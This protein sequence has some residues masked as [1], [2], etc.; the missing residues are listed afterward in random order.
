MGI[1]TRLKNV[2]EAD[3]YELIDQKEQ[4]NPIAMLSHY[5]RQCEKEVE[6]AKKLVERH[7]TLE[8]QYEKEWREAVKMAEKRKHQATVAKEAGADELFEHAIKEEKQY[9]ERASRLF[10]L[11]EQTEKELE[12]LE[13]KY[14]QM[15]HKLKDM[16]VKKLELMGRENSA[17]AHYRMNQVLEE[18]SYK[19]KTF[20]RFEEMERYLDEL[21]QK[22][23]ARYME[24]T[25]DSKITQ[26]EKELKAKKTTPSND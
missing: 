9:E 25:F 3:L 5:L 10:T 20:T 15:K 22:V 1:F 11:K 23:Q 12:Q 18:D 24:N 26:L 8:K 16:H 6:K 2:V 21:E 17:R 13:Q 19:E 4:K 14:E 7:E